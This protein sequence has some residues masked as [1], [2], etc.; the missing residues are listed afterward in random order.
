MSEN[1]IKVQ[2]I[3]EKVKKDL[4]TIYKDKEL[5]IETLTKI[6]NIPKSDVQN[7]LGVESQ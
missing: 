2:E 1:S 5:N 7:I 6:L 3:E 4:E